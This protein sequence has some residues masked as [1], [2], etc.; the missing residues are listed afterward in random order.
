[1]PVRPS[2]KL[3]LQPSSKLRN[4]QSSVEMEAFL[5]HVCKTRTLLTLIL[6]IWVPI[7]VMAQTGNAPVSS[8]RPSSL[9]IGALFT[10]NSA[11][12]RSAKPAILAAIEEVNSDSSVLEG[13][14]LN[15][16]FHDTNCSGFLGTVEALQLIENDVVAAIGPQSSGIAHV[17]SHVVNELHVPLLSFGATDPSLSALQYPYFVRTTQSDY[18]QM[19]A[20]A[21]M[22]EYFG[23]REVIAIFVDDDCGRNGISVLGDA[24]AKKR[25]KIAYK[26]AFSPGA[27]LSDINDLLVGVNLMESRVY[28]VHV[29]PDSGL[30]IF[31]VAKDL[32]MMTSGYVWIATDWLPTNLDSL[33]PPDPD[34][35]NLLQG[36]VALRHHSPDTDLKKSFASKW[37]K[38]KHEGSLGF[39]SY[40]LYA[41]DSIWL[42]ARALDVFS[43]KEGLYL[44]LVTQS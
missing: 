34:K 28:I 9:N 26:A 43:M 36:V 17:I 16:I 15:I 12:G 33:V 25:S 31:S 22:V 13:T 41:Y 39:N 19:Y 29:N 21:D 14:K 32:G 30:S 24:L 23:W 35:M 40:A 27:P 6:C 8:K 1:M 37:S 11:I 10:F 44:S 42:A 5:T 18:F 4:Q 7:E 38:L 2:S 3:V 20:V